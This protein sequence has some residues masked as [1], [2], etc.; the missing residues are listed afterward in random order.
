LVRQISKL[1]RLLES[2]LLDRRGIKQLGL[3]SPAPGGDLLGRLLSLPAEDQL[4]DVREPED[5]FRFA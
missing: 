2:A 1:D 4:V 3:R 5:P